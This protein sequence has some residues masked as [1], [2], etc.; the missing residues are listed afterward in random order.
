MTALLWTAGVLQLVVAA[1]NVPVA[2]VLRL[3][4]EFGRLSPLPR[5]IVLTHHAY[6]AGL[7][8][9]FGALCLLF[10]PEL[11]SGAP[12]ALFLDALLALFWGTRLVL[13]L[14]V[15]DRELRGRYRTADLGFSLAFAGLT[16]TFL[17]CLGKGLA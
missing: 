13:Q 4:E 12:L 8:A 7:I 6:I 11:A 3:R 16:A 15:Y 14:F 10:A 9:A 17:A 2:R 5:H 1:A